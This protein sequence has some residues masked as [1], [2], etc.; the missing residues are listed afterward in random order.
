M[1]DALR[2]RVDKFETKVGPDDHGDGDDH[3]DIGGDDHGDGN[4]DDK[5]RCQDE[6]VV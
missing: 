5:I 4:S 1:E 2:D 6:P 3:G